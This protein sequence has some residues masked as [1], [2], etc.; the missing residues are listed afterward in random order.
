MFSLN[1]NYLKLK[2][3]YLFP[4]IARRVKEFSELYPDK[5]ARLIRCGVGDV[6]EPL[7]ASARQAMHE[8]VDEMGHRETF[9]GYGPEQGYE[10]LRQLIVKNDY[11]SRGIK[12]EEDEIFVSD[13]S[14]C[15]GGNIL[16]ILGST[17]Q[18]AVM[19]PVYPVYV[20]TNVMMGHTGPAREDG[21]Y[22]GMVYLTCK[23]ENY[24]VPALPQEKVSIIYLC[25]PNNP[26]GAVASREALTAWVNYALEHQSLIL[27]DAA[28]EAYIQDPSIP[29]S[30]YEIPGAR[31]CAIEFRSFSKSGGFTGVR[32]GF[33]V[34]P[35]ELM[36]ATA[37]GNRHSLHALWYRRFT[38]MFNGVSYITQRGA[39]A[40]YSEQGKKE[41]QAL[42]QH[43][44]GN[45]AILREAVTAAGLSVY[46]GSNAPYLW[47]KGPAGESSWQTFDRMLHDKQIVVTPGSGFGRAGEGF[48]RMS[49]FNSR[50]NVMEVVKRL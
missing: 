8:A 48:F 39:A 24:F 3:G 10:F 30:I 42:I 16:D 14:K 7:P 47:I 33:T 13:G 1:S 34:V 36:G 12:V 28:Y 6:T 32:C 31:E 37:Q 25:Y 40:L 18:I 26:T 27:F 41:V 45:A 21:S 11:A 23:P 43:Y 49:A 4:E 20:D 19:D 46:G 35:K 50:E 5:A 29:H 22:E 38:T 15:D 44:M 9:H 2:A 17:N